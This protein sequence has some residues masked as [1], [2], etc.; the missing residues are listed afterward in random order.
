MAVKYTG[1]P[2]PIRSGDIY[3]IEAETSRFTELPFKER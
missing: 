3:V 2:F 1:E